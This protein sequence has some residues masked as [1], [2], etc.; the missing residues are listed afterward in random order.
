MSEKQLLKAENIVV[1]FGE[2]EILHFDRM[3]VYEGERVGLVGANGAGKTTLLR[4]LAGELVPENGRVERFCEM[5]FFHQ[6]GEGEKPQTEDEAALP[7]A[8]QYGMEAW[9]GREVKEFKVKEKLW[10]K[11]VS[12]GE[13]VRIRLAQIF[14]S[15][16][17]LLLLDEPTS[18][19]DMAGISVLTERLGHIETMILVSHDR[20]LLNAVCTRIV[21]IEDGGLKSYDGNYDSYVQCRKAA[22]ERQQ[23]EYEQYRKKKSRLEKVYLAKKGKAA[24]IEKRPRGM[25]AH[26]ANVLA[27]I[28]NHKPE[29]KARNMERSARNVKKR[30]EH[31]EVKE[32]P[33]ETARIRPEFRLYDAPEN[34]ILIEG[35]HM[36]FSYD[37]ERKL[38]EDAGFAIQNKSR[39]AIVGENGAGK[40]T[41]LHLIADSVQEKQKLQLEGGKIRVVPKARLG[42]LEQNLSM[43]APEKTVL[44][45]VMEQSIFKED[46]ARTILARLLL[47]EKD[48]NKKVQMLSGGE[49]IKLAFARLFVDN[50][51]VL[52]LDEPTNYLDIASMEALEQMFS[53]YEGTLVFV[54]H[55]EAF[56]RAVATEILIVEDGKIRAFRGTPEEYF[57]FKQSIP[58]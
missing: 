41:L 12:G 7:L 39:V 1:R 10:Q 13:D 37:G 29:D 49:R 14:G 56:I 45:N 50:V 11:A 36:T 55:D 20:S 35:E 47:S 17:P 53:V 38:F 21:E 34:R 43:L 42:L 33:K 27:F 2:Q 30:L 52:V 46:L 24:A 48:L 58:L 40:T 4:V 51:N 8:F 28:G 5:G 15:R 25:S 19:L 9:D 32:K 6:F 26:E 44:E 16:K 54:S 22:R 31:M 23:L 3:S 18:N 57:S